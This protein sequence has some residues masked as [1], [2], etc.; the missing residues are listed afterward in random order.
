MSV[1]C[2]LVRP[3]RWGWVFRIDFTCYC[4]LPPVMY[5]YFSFTRVTFKHTQ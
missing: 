3:A 4:I 1:E 5:R 2:P